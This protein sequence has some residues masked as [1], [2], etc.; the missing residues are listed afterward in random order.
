MPRPNR[1]CAGGTIHHV[2]NRA[3]GKLMIFKKPADFLAFERILSQ[4]LARVDM[5]LCGYCIMGN[6][7]HLLLWPREDGDLST[8]MQWITTT[9]TQRWHVAHG[10]GCVLTAVHHDLEAEG[11]DV[12]T[13]VA[14]ARRVE[15]HVLKG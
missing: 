10:G 1:Q 8:F 12:H 7:W 2:I 14:L 11:V 3:N 13:C 5:R 6:H 4:G 9:H 15:H